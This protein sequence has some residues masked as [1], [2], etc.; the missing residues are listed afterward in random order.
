MKYDSVITNPP[1]IGNRYLP[2][3]IKKFIENK[4]SEYKSDIFSSFVARVINMCKTEGHI[5]MLTPYV[6]M[7]ISSYEALLLQEKVIQHLIIIDS[8]AYG[9]R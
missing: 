8:S 4:Y 2:I 9:T 3:K 5:G 7:Y 1:Y 6:W